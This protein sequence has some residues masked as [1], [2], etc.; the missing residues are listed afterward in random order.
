MRTNSICDFSA[1]SINSGF[2][3]F[4]YLEKLNFEESFY[5]RN[6]Y[7]KESKE[8][9][10][11]SIFSIYKKNSSVGICPYGIDF[12]LMSEHFQKKKAN[13]FRYWNKI[14]MEFK[15]LIE[16]N[17]NDPDELPIDYIIPELSFSYLHLPQSARGDLTTK[18]RKGSFMFSI[19]VT[20]L[21]RSL[22]FIK[23]N[24]GSIWIKP[25]FKQESIVF[26]QMENSSGVS[27][28]IEINKNGYNLSKVES[29][30]DI[31]RG[32]TLFG[33]PEYNFSQSRIFL[34]FGVSVTTENH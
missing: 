22:T 16:K 26:N 12:D 23:F 27:V 29:S 18:A 28:E 6:R 17:L 7:N 9:T 14:R 2:N 5:Y 20:P 24:V 11:Y 19:S 32:I 33:G 8:R 1:I 34:N 3:D 30:R 21:K 10:V 13:T 15:F 4:K 25:Y 31:Y